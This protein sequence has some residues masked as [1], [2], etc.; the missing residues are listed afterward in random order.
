MTTFNEVANLYKTVSEQ[1]KQKH[2]CLQSWEITFN[3]R[4]KNCMGRAVRGSDGTKKIEL[5]T[6]I[7]ALNLNTPNF[8]DKIKQTIIHEWSH[9]LDWELYKGWGHGSS[10]RKCMMSFGL[11]PERCFDANLWLVQ[12]NKTQYVIRNN[13]TGR[14][15][16]YLD[17]YPDANALTKAHH[18]HRFML[19]RPAHED[20]ELI[21]LESGKSKILD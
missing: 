2:S 12:P 11:V 16:K 5:S 14:V 3:S 8:L 1:V 21:H 4:I 10:W 7:I 20:L 17:K 13:T 18:W 9:A 19:M 15:W 6:K